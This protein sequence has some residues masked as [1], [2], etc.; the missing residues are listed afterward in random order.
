MRLKLPFRLAR[1]LTVVLSIVIAHVVIFWL[2][3]TMKI[4][5]PDLGPVFATLDLKAEAES[6]PPVEAPSPDVGQK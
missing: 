1:G 2:F 3:N 5:M 6:K 4:P